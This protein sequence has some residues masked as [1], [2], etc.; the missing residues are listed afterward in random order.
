MLTKGQP[1]IRRRW[2]A[3]ISAP[4]PETSCTGA[5][6]D[7]SDARPSVP[8]DRLRFW[9]DD[10]TAVPRS[11]AIYRTCR[12]ADRC[13]RLFQKPPGPADSLRV[14]KTPPRQSSA[15]ELKRKTA[16]GFTILRGHFTSVLSAESGSV[17]WPI[18]KTSTNSSKS[19]AAITR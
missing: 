15:V 2:T 3:R 18:K 19:F 5:A 11:N 4:R 17:S 8:A 9:I 6:D 14:A 1:M 7:E 12:S 10:A 13:K 16:A